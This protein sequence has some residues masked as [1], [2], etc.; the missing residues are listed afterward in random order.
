MFDWLK[1]HP[2]P[3]R[4]E[5][6]YT[7]VVTYAL[8]AEGLYAFA[9]PGLRIDEWNGLGFLAVAFVQTRRL[10]P[11]FL[12]SFLGQDFFLSGY[13]VFARYR[14]PDGRERA[15]LLVLRT[16]VRLRPLR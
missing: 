5:F 9:P 8:P 3:I 13:R 1:R 15:R 10:R 16:L 7:L 14:R 6:Q 2:V 11:T 12:P 4:A